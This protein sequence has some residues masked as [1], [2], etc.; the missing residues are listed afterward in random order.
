MNYVRLQN[1]LLNTTSES[2]LW[3]A[4]PR[5]RELLVR[6]FGL[7]KSRVMS[8]PGVEWNENVGH[9][10]ATRMSLLIALMPKR[11]PR[12]SSA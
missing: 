8:T 1:R 6:S 5:Y 2:L 9:G 12:R 3:D 10:P 7:Q 11:H 4:D